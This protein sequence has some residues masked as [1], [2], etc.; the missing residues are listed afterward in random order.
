MT[1]SAD[2]DELDN[3]L[4]AAAPTLDEPDRALAVAVYRA[5]AAAG[6]PVPVPDIASRAGMR[7]DHAEACLDAWP[8]V[9]RDDAGAIVSL[10]G[11]ATVP[12]PHS[13]RV[14]GVDLWTWCAWDPL[15][16]ARIVGPAEVT[17]KDPMT[18][19]AVTYRLAGNGAISDLSH[20][21][22]V[23]SFLRSDGA[24]GDDVITSFCH[25]VHHF[26][27]VRTAQRW[28]DQHAGTVVIE[29]PAAVE[30]ARRWVHRVFGV[31]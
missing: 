29:L 5:L 17:T 9:F 3:G 14:G 16:I 12:M 23:M 18:D 28:T 30:L 4:A 6:K 20:P 13:F 2:L 10:W 27:S 25:Y 8:G 11:L 7:A 1:A 21:E 22:G 19:E 15:F 24:W 26:T 31:A